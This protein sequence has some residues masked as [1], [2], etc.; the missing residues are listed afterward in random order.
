MKSNNPSVSQ[1]ALEKLTSSLSGELSD[2][3]IRQCGFCCKKIDSNFT[4]YSICQKMS[5]EEAFYCSF[6]LRNGFNHKGKKDVL[7]LSFRAIFAHFYYSFYLNPTADKKMWLME[8]NDYIEAHKKAGLTNPAFEYDD[9]T[10]LWFIDFNKIGNSKK[11]IFV[12]EIYK[13]ILNILMTFNFYENIPDMILHVFFQKYKNAIDEFYARRFRPE[14][15]FMLI[16][17]LSNC[18]V[19]NRISSD[20]SRN[21]CINLMKY[22][23]IIDF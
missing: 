2:L 5:G 1:V 13:T 15:K 10:F 16:P 11:R 9:E 14:N 7:I 6:C 4:A 18:G 23:K 19:Q 22:K 17:T 12:Q 3:F 8:I 20:K 21:F